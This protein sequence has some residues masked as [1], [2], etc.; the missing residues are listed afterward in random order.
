[1]IEWMCSRFENV[2]LIFKLIIGDV[3]MKLL[4]SVAFSFE[5]FSL[6]GLFVRP[7]HVF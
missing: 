3:V 2:Y 5:L 4:L 6:R 1:M 7:N